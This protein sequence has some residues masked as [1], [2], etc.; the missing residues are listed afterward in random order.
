MKYEKTQRGNPHGLTVVQ[1]QIPVRSIERFTGTGGAVEVY[2]ETKRVLVK[3]Q[4]ELFATKRSWDQRAEAGYMKQIENEYQAI[5]DRVL[6]DP[7]SE[8]ADKDHETITYFYWLWFHRSRVVAANIEDIPLKGV[9]GGSYS[10]DD[11]EKLEKAGVSFIRKDG[12]I[13]G[14]NMVGLRLQRDIDSGAMSW[15]GRKWGVVIAQGREFLHPDAPHHNI[16]PVTPKLAFA[17]DSQTGYI[18]EQNL[19]EI[20]RAMVQHA[21]RYFFARDL[22]CT[23]DGIPSV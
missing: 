1:H 5:A 21:Y 15:S 2:F 8:L 22:N 17:L 7:D 14:R 16:L 10:K 6:A 3:P 4:D 12:V 19:D 9:T 20:N 11:E 18:S 23:I 13:P